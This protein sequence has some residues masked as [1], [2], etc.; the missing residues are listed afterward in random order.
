MVKRCTH[1]IERTIVLVNRR[2]VVFGISFDGERRKEERSAAA[3]LLVNERADL[4]YI[5]DGR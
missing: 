4:P 3:I 2:N 5:D 1:E